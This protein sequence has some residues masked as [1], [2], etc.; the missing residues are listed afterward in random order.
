MDSSSFV[1]QLSS[2]QESARRVEK[3]L[4]EENQLISNLKKQI[5]YLQNTKIEQVQNQ[6]R[7]YEFDTLK[8]ET[9]I[10][11]HFTHLKQL[12]KE[13][14]NLMVLMNFD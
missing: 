4:E 7:Q 5:D 11:A 12:A 13:V 2:M 10:S 8:N 9:E 6:V 14:D 1:E 3:Q